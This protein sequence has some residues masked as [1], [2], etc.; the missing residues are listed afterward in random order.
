MAAEL[1]AEKSRRNLIDF[2]QFTLKGY[3][4]ADHLSLI[5][6]RL[7]AVERGEIKRLAIFCPPRHGK[8]ETASIRFPAWYLGRNPDKRVILTSYAA[9][10]SRTFSRKVRNLIEEGKYGFVFDA[11]TTKDYR[12]VDHWDLFGKR[13]GMVSSG[14]GGPIT[15]YGADL[16]IIDDPVKNKED[17]ESVHYREMTWEWFQSVARTRLEPNAAIILIMTRWHKDDLGGRLLKNQEGW[18]V[19]NLPALAEKDDPLGRREGEALWPERF[20]AE[21]LESL[22]RDVGS[23]AWHALFQGNPL[24][25][26]SQIFNRDWFQYY[27]ELPPA[28]ARGGGID[29]ATS[30]KTSADNMSLVDVC[31]DTQGFL[32]LDDVFL[33]KVSVSAFSNHVSNQHKIKRYVHIGL[34]D[35][36]AGE[37]VRQRIDEVGRE[38]KTYP[39]VS[40]FTTSTDKV[41]RAMEWQPLVE[42]GTLKFKAGNAKIA[43][44]IDRLVDFDGTDGTIDDDIDATGFAI[45]AVAAGYI[46]ADDIG[47]SEDV[48]D[49]EPEGDR[50]EQDW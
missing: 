30:K 3:E 38:K 26:E 13:G 5:A 41:V 31:R 1:W 29:T 21:A 22:K 42:N 24:D 39:P 17:A 36:N 32:Y 10:L 4:R 23:R 37:A 25:P 35:N 14:V 9:T 2:C 45:K 50:M 6:E 15:G 12:A 28:T 46:S 11:K 20:G 40:P 47:T 27:Q 48:R 16:F 7:E 43:D 34:E 49:F 33:D 8:S 18:T 19:V 44:L